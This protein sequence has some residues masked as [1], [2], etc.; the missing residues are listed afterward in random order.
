VGVKKN[1]C[2]P[3]PQQDIY[4]NIAV[5]R[6]RKKDYGHFLL[7]NLGSHAIEKKTKGGG[8]ARQAGREGRTEGGGKEAGRQTEKGRREMERKRQAGRKDG[9]WE[10][11]QVVTQ[12]GKQDR[13]GKIW[14]QTW[15]QTWQGGKGGRE[16]GG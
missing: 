14:R 3:R 6:H 7:Y 8:E 15:R 9:K 16:G 10:R 2:P 13:R 11:R 12:G 1:K 5:S 4:S